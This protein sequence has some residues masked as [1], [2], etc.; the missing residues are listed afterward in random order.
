MIGI[1]ITAIVQA[2]INGAPSALLNSFLKNGMNES[3]SDSDNDQVAATGERTKIPQMPTTTDGRAASR[4]IKEVATLETF[5]GAMN[6]IKNATA[7][8]A[9]TAMIKPKIDTTIVPTSIGQIWK[10]PSSVVLSQVDPVTNA[11]PCCENVDHDF[12]LKKTRT[13]STKNIVN[14][15]AAVEIAK[16][17]RSPLATCRVF[18]GVRWI[19]KLTPKD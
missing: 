7:M 10:V 11:S 6:S 8:D 15:A 14:I 16:N 13:A 12:M 2:A 17:A 1:I 18:M 5:G 4:S 9:G 19:S 3:V